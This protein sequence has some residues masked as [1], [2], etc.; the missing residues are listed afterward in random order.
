MERGGGKLIPDERFV[1]YVWMTL[2]IRIIRDLDQKMSTIDKSGWWS[3]TDL[4]SVP[5]GV[6]Q[7][8]G[9]GWG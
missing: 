6:V 8:H 5:L 4:E 3:N 7:W 1:V 9:G 2:D